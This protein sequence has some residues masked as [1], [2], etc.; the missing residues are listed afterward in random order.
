[1]RDGC[2]WTKVLPA[3]LMGLRLEKEEDDMQPWMLAHRVYSNGVEACVWPLL[4]N[5][6]RF[7]IIDGPKSFSS[8]W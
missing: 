2:I 8:S 7:S 6:A 1:M 3:S 4:F 5:R